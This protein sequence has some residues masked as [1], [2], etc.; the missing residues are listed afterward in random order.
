[1]AKETLTQ[2]GKIKGFKPTISRI[3]AALDKLK[4]AGVVTKLGGSYCIED[5]LFAEHLTTLTVGKEL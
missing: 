3:R 4:R 2:L 1:M 5:R